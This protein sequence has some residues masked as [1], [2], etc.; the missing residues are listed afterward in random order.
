MRLLAE[1]SCLPSC[2]TRP[3]SYRWWR[4]H[5]P[6]PCRRRVRCCGRQRHAGVS[7]RLIGRAVMPCWVRPG[8]RAVGPCWVHYT[9]TCAC[10]TQLQHTTAALHAAL[11]QQRPPLRPRGRQPNRRTRSC[12]WRA[13]PALKRCGRRWRRSPRRACCAR[14][15]R[16]AGGGRKHGRDGE[17]PNPTVEVVWFQV[18]TEPSHQVFVRYLKAPARQHAFSPAVTRGRLKRANWTVGWE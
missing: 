14:A 11:Q 8:G 18:N 7:P 13:R 4:R 2:H 10:M 1:L 9:C 17:Y 3:S 16:R 5:L 15:G 6:A 12:V